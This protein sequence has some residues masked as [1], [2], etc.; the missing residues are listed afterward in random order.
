MK[1]FTLSCCV[2]TS[3]NRRSSVP[4]SAVITR[5]SRFINWT[6]V[7]LHGFL[8]TCHSVGFVLGTTAEWIWLSLPKEVL[9]VRSSERVFL[10]IFSGVWFFCSV[11]YW[12]F[13]FLTFDGNKTLRLWGGLFLSWES[14][15][16]IGLMIRS[17]PGF[18]DQVMSLLNFWLIIIPFPSFSI[19]LDGRLLNSQ[20]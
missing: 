19:L 2:A 20:F 15:L 8:V 14:L 9:K 10:R 6:I 16:L 7:L 11:I 18:Y 3:S 4:S 5:V 12:T 17:D 13:Y 1:S